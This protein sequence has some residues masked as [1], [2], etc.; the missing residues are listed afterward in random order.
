MTWQVFPEHQR[1]IVRIHGTSLKCLLFSR[2]EIARLVQL[3]VT[4][5]LR[6][7]GTK[8]LAQVTAAGPIA[9]S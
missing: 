9:R 2:I 7:L 1:N 4:S 6:V 3:M 5:V 8:Y